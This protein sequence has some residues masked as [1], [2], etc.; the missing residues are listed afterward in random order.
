MEVLELE[1]GVSGA[2]VEAESERA[3]L[4]LP[5]KRAKKHPGRQELPAHLPRLEKIIACTLEQCVCGNCGQENSVIGYEKSEQLDVNPA[6][7]FAVVT[8][9]TNR[10]CNAREE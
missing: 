5:L 3:Q 2:E 7:Y 6:E 1:K 4:K 9:H 10:S 8:N